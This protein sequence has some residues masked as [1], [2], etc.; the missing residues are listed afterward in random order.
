VVEQWSACC[1]EAEAEEGTR[2]VVGRTYIFGTGEDAE[3]GTVASIDGDQVTVQWEQGCVTTQPRA[4]L[5]TE[6]AD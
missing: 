1:L 4:A 6:A 5:V 3:R 2:L